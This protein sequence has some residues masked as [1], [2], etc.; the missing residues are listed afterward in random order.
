MKRFEKVKS[1]SLIPLA[2]WLSM[3]L[4]FAVDVSTPLGVTGWVFYLLPIVLGLYERRP[5]LPLQ[6]AALATLAILLSFLFNRALPEYPIW[7]AQLNRVFGVL[8][9]WSVAFVVRQLVTTQIELR[10]RDWIRTGQ[11][12]L[13]ERMQGEQSV[14]QLGD[15]ILRFLCEYLDVPVA[16]FYCAEPD[17][18]FRRRATYSLRSMPPSAPELLSAGETILG[19]A[20]KDRRAIRLDRVPADY[21]PISSALGSTTPR[22]LVA[23]PA[24]VDGTVK[25]A[26]ELGFLRAV[27]VADMNL[28]QATANSIA[29]V[30][31]SAEHRE[32]QAQLLAETQ[33]QAAELQTQQEELKVS[34][35]EL[36]E[37][38][39]ALKESQARL[40]AQQA[41]LEVANRQLEEQAQTL[42]RQ[43]DEL[44]RAQAE[45]VE[46]AEA[47][48]RANRYKSEF[49][50]NM[51][52]ELRTPLNSTLIL[53][54]LLSDNK[55]GNLTSEQVRFASTIHSS[56]NDLLALINDI[57]DLSR[58]EAGRVDI[59]P[60]EV[61]VSSLLGALRKTFRPVAEQRKLTLDLSAAP[62]VPD[63]LRTDPLR[64]QQIL[65]NL[66]ANALKFTEQGGVTLAVT[67]ADDDHVAFAVRDTG[68]GIP[69]EQRE[70]IFEAFRQANGG[71]QRKYGGSGLGLTISRELARRMGGSL[72]L[73]ST[74]GKGSTFRLVIPRAI[75]APVVDESGVGLPAPTRGPA[76]PAA[77]GRQAVPSPPQEGQTR[78]VVPDDRQAM[79]SSERSILVIEDDERFAVILRDLARELRFRCLVATRGHEGLQLAEQFGPRAILLDIHLPD[80]SGLAILEQIKRNPITRHI[81]V[82][83]VS[84][85]DCTQQAFEL[86]AVGYALKPVKREQV[87]QAI[88][89]LER[90]LEQDV[91]RILVVEDVQAQRESIEALLRREGVEIV[92]VGFG[93]E[94]LNRLREETFDC[95]V[96]DLTL[97]DI[98]GYDVLEKMA[99]GEAFSFP[100]VIVYTGRALLREEEARLRR[101][102]SSVIIKG[103]RSPERL[104]DEVS[105]FLHQVES[106][107]PPEQQRVL[108]LV[109]QREAAFEGRTIMAVED[110]SRNIFALSSILEPKG[111]KML[112]ARNGR[113]ALDTL[114]RIAKSPAETVDLVLMDIMM[115]VLDGLMATRE[116]RRRVEWKNLP[117]I[118]L[119]AKAMPDDRQKCI[120]AGANDYIAKPLDIER[121]VSLVKVWLP[122]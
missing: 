68:I 73:D 56:G 92:S 105:L 75:E 18:R 59:R 97:P 41:E 42:G 93:H 91:R 111:A 52:H 110:D 77:A 4:V 63:S 39:Q 89:R 51:S 6:L 121:L 100:P 12:G 50:A 95:M 60:E 44:A 19:Q 90:K 64:L 9:I 46:R 119:T 29:V 85:S 101:F 8:T 67:L 112:I 82:H 7:L 24:E 48:E 2:V 114:D 13:S 34:N 57:L 76:P 103:A 21:L 16:A 66:L 122:K 10:E 20:I 30:V 14:A 109:R 81:P 88:E 37:Q 26:V 22:H 106:S 54:K 102:A 40:E 15:S 71:T 47:L 84:V 79:T 99:A 53:A 17:G 120:E 25:G 38:S 49:L 98:S 70:A 108:Q 107:L 116:I 104:L 62:N 117:I 33:R 115:P 31:R 58:I 61:G 43:R 23:V 3:A 28:L 32:R 65:R 80:Q 45:L 78:R 118:A 5:W 96:L 11:R 94:A 1:G 36:E 55:E 72:S 27:G 74:A 113:E 35:E 87:V 86:G 69:V 83:V